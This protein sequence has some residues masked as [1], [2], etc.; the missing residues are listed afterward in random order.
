[1]LNNIPEVLKE[2]LEEAIS[3]MMIESKLPGVSMAISIDGNLAYSKGFGARNLER[4]LPATPYTLYGIGSNTKSYTAF[5]IMQLVEQDKINVEDPVS[6]Y[7][8]FKLGKKEDPITIHHLLSH[9]SG[10]TSLGSADEV[11]ICRASN[12][13]EY[14]IPMSN[15]SDFY[16][17]VNGGKREVIAKPGNRFA[18]FNEGFTL[19]QAIIQKVSGIKYSDYIK[20]KILKPLNMNRST[21]SKEDFEKENDTAT[22]YF[23]EL[24]NGRIIK[25]IPT[26]HPFDEFIE[27]AGGLLSSVYEQLNYLQ[28]NINRGEFNG[29][30]LLKSELIEKMH[31][32]H[33]EM[34]MVK[35]RLGDFGREGYGYGWIVLEDFFGEKIV[36]HGG[37]TMVTAFSLFFLPSKKIAI[38]VACNSNRG[39]ALTTGLPVI[40]IS[41]LLGKNP[42]KEIQF[43]SMSEKLNQ[44][45]GDYE[46]YKGIHKMKIFMQGGL[47]YLKAEDRRISFGGIPQAMSVPLIPASEEL[48]DLNFYILNG[49]GAKSNVEFQVDRKGNVDLYIAEWTFHKI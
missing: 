45:T 30:K 7:I 21:F 36:V 14:Y 11:I 44:L 15:W 25:Q 19:L 10:I 47:L 46:T 43:L 24:K 31:D 22:A 37:N 27:G 23:G 39:S 38:S 26:T 1:M 12:L 40:I 29:V 6:K 34:D 28:M 5:A 41:T 9:S 35:E 8:P 17:F 18:Y 3:S 13:D 42:I 33:I 49:P 32:I 16:R 4:N 20:E 48:E 2:Q